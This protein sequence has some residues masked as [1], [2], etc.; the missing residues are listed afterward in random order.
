ME[1]IQN[2][3]REKEKEILGLE[4]KKMTLIKPLYCQVLVM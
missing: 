4:S 1:D 2:K 3:Q